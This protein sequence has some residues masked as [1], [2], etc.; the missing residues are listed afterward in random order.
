MQLPDGT[1]KVAFR[2]DRKGEAWWSGYR[3]NIAIDKVIVECGGAPPAPPAPPP[4]LCS[5]ECGS[6]WR[7]YASN[8]FCDD[9]GAGSEYYRCSFGSD[10]NV[11][12]TAGSNPCATG[13]CSPVPCAVPPNAQDCGVRVLPVPCQLDMDLV[14]RRPLKPAPANAD[15]S[16]AGRASSVRVACGR[17][18]SSTRAAACGT[19]TRSLK[20][21]L[22]ACSI[23]SRS[24][25]TPLQ[26]LWS[27]S[28][29]TAGSC[30]SE[31]RRGCRTTQLHSS[32]RSARWTP[33]AV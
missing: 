13:P 21:L 16:A 1:A 27:N 28:R 11:R 6:R 29:R 4:G 25:Q 12:G 10:C 17:C 26:W 30:V 19:T 7:S 18:S 23:N 32:R 9:G 31:A 5:D 20:T 33:H 24:G 2:V 8:G 15:R 3:G 22:G 14:R